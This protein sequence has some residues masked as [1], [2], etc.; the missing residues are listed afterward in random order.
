MAFDKQP[1]VPIQRSP[2]DCVEGWD[3]IVSRLVG[4]RVIA[5]E[6]YPGVDE[7]EVARELAARLLNP[8]VFMTSDARHS[9]FDLDVERST[10]GSL[11]AH[12]PSP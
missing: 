9:T 3:A 1:Y 12:R 6:C 5:V 10:F 8:F 2:G 7:C 11:P 4:K